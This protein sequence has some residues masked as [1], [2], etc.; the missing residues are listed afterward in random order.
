MP[1][2]IAPEKPDFLLPFMVHLAKILL[3]MRSKSMLEEGNSDW[4]LKHA[5]LLCME[6][7]SSTFMKYEDLYANMEPF[8]KKHVLGCLQSNQG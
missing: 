2:S 3:D 7:L 6:T 8:L 5:C 1:S 4:A